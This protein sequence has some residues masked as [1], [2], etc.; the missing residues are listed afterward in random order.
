M[1]K[2]NQGFNLIEIIVSIAVVAMLLGIASVS[3]AKSKEKT[4]DT[5]RKGDISQIGRLL[6]LDCYL[7]EQGGG[8]YDISEVLDDL[9]DKYP[10]Q[11][12][13][14]TGS[15]KDPSSTSDETLY[16]YTVT[17][18][19][20]HCVL[21]TNLENETEITTLPDISKPTMG[22]KIGVF[23]D[24]VAGWNGSKKYYQMSR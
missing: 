21:Y 5:I 14:L 3:L 8:T 19:G 1:Q 17:D 23:E 7:P 16:K 11:T 10:K 4:R 22:G 13:Y 20:K 2:N 6:S 12:T 9:S 15:L 24:V 18:D